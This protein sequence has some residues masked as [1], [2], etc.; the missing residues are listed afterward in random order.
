VHVV[1]VGFSNSAGGDKYVYQATQEGFLRTAGSNISPY[2]V[3]G[4]DRAYSPVSRPICDAPQMF[5]GNKPT[6]GGNLI[7][8]E[9][10]KQEL[11]EHEP[12]AARF[13]RR[14]MS[15]SDLIDN[16]PALFR[17]IAQPSS[18]YLALPEVSSE[19]RVY[20]PMA[21][22]AP[23]IICSNTVQFIPD[24]KLF[25]F[26]ILT[27]AMHMS[28]MRRIAGRLKSDYR[29]SNSLVYNNFPWPP[30]ITTLQRN[31]IEE[32]GQAVLDA[33]ASFPD[34]NLSQLYDPLLMPHA[35]LTAHQKLDRAVERCYR[36]EAFLNEQARVE[37]LF[38]L[39]EQLATPLLPSPPS[40]SRRTRANR[41]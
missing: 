24:A 11:F 16:R 38:S 20:L 28:W 37:F 8:S 3:F 10:E 22:F 17:Q 29:Y 5:W 34:S 7:L 15:G 18:S 9:E 30:N 35:L 1:I 27:S 6:D 25:H 19:R 26:G 2:L 31:R 33:S 21:M 32:L 36:S 23:E 41:D 13:V 4:S 14:Y 40:R 39:Y 12:E